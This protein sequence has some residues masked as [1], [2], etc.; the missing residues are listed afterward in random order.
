MATK[1]DYQRVQEHTVA[2]KNMVLDLKNSYN[3]LNNG[4][5]SEEEH[6]CNELVSEL[7][8]IEAQLMELFAEKES[9]V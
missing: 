2:L 4:V 7:S 9:E 6:Q 1:T 8:I 3:S 5:F